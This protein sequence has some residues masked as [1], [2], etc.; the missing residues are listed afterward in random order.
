[1]SVRYYM[2]KFFLVLVFWIKFYFIRMRNLKKNYV[3]LKYYVYSV[4]YI[5]IVYKFLKLENFYS[6]L[7]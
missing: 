4:K 1:M 6:I 7:E 3:S 5:L 2:N